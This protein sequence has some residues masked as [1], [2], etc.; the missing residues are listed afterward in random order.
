MIWVV[1][2]VAIDMVAVREK[3]LDGTSNP[4]DIR[5]GLG[6]VGYRIFSNLEAPRRFITALAT[7]PISRWARE[8]LES[9][10]DAV[11][12]EVTGR[13]SRPPLY[14]AL[15]ESGALKVAASDFRI[16]EQSLSAEFVMSQVGTPGPADFLV[17]DANLSP[18]LVAALV[19]R[20]ADQTRVVFEPV[21]VEKTARHAGGL[22]KLFLTTP[23]VEEMDAFGAPDILRFMAERAIAHI[24]VTRGPA[25]TRLVR[26]W[27]VRGVPP[28][29]V[30]QA[31]DTT[32]A[33]DQLLALLLSF[34][35]N[36]SGLHDAVRSAMDRVEDSLRKDRTMTE[37]IR[38]SAEVRDAL[39][40]RRPVVAFESTII[41]HGMPWPRN[42]DTALEAEAIARAS[43]AVPATV[44]VMDG[45]VVVGLKADELERLA[46]EAG[47]LKVSRRDLSWALATGRTG[48][49]TVSATMFA[50]FRAGIDVFATGGIGG[51]HR[52]AAESFDIS[53]DLTELAVTSVCVV[54]AG[55][56]AIL[57]IPKTLEMLETLGVPVVCFDTPEFPAF[58]SRSSGLPA[59]LRVDAPRDLAVMLAT[60][61]SLQLPQGILVAQPVPAAEEIPRETMDA[62]ISRALE[63]MRDRKISGKAVTPFL[64]SR[65]VELSGG[66]SLET[67]V[68]LFHNNV[69]LACRIAS[70]CAELSRR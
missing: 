54:S 36:G 18:R 60:Q 32:G 26:R 19:E 68:K 2:A 15:M 4:S 31:P 13:E 50:A 49:T 6:G 9:D 14:L 45:T 41:S 20:Y 66:A 59:P 37:R 65:I 35:H 61:R 22:R 34:L 55:A 29:V 53:A 11:I 25:G 23:T 57:D 39:E 33:G 40:A 24:L 58:Y 17:L 8:A 62:W 30:A 27:A 7:D 63:E 28:R 43:G 21:S 5:L 51:V 10:G 16:V 56:K 3:F 44:A 38:L 47:V 70:A 52:G 48:A 42:R 64:L 67:N 69:R 46:T 12:Q 1:G